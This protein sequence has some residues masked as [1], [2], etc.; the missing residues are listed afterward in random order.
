MS[1]NLKTVM[2]ISEKEING[3]RQDSAFGKKQKPL[4]LAM[5]GNGGES[6]ESASLQ[7]A[8]SKER[9]LVVHVLDLNFKSS[10]LRGFR[11]TST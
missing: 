5:E 2:M 4:I 10:I 8:H 7:S 11:Q 3:S 9:N 6:V 1:K